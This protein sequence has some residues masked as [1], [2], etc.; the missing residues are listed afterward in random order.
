MAA[1]D[2][3]QIFITWFDRAN[4]IFRW[5]DTG[6]LRFGASRCCRIYC[7][8]DISTTESLSRLRPDRV[9][10]YRRSVGCEVSG[11]FAPHD[12]SAGLVFAVRVRLKLLRILPKQ[13]I[14]NSSLVV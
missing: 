9:E 10:D 2:T 5:L 11:W 13:D 8:P 1:A 12:H 7:I 14:G 3:Q 6:A 4:V